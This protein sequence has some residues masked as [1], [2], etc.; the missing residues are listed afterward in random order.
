M[1]SLYSG[2]NQSYPSKYIGHF[3]LKPINPNIEKTT[4]VD[5]K[6]R[7]SALNTKIGVSIPTTL[8]YRNYSGV[9]YVTSVKN[10]GLCGACWSFAGT[11]QY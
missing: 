3:G 6:V 2:I 11:A 10:Q 8:D 7:T 4:A 5:K 9:N 1:D